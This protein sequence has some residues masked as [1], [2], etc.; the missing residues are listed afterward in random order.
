ME[1][2]L[3]LFALQRAETGAWL[4][5]APTDDPLLPPIVL[6]GVIESGPRW[7]RTE[8]LSEAAGLA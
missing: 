7:A 6:V 2:E 3:P 5:H 1:L 4:V 8:P